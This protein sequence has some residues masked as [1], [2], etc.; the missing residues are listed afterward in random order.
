[1]GFAYAY[2]HDQPY[3]VQNGTV[4]VSEPTLPT[5]KTTGSESSRTTIMV[6]SL[7][8]MFGNLLDADIGKTSWKEKKATEV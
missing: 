8:Q 2:G 3:T 5:R 1:M 7:Q 6:S 4:T